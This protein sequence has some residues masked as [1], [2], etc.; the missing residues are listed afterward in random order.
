MSCIAC[1]RYL[2]DEC[3]TQPCCCRVSTKVTEVELES[4]PLKNAKVLKDP[5]STGRKRAVKVRTISPGDP[6]DWKLQKNCG[7]GK[8]PIV[9]CLDGEAKH[10]HHGPDKSTLNNE[11][12]NLH[13]LCNN[14]HNR[15]HNGNDWCIDSTLLHD[16]KPATVEEIAKNEADWLGG[17]FS[18]WT[19]KRQAFFKENK[20]IADEEH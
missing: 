3:Y 9:G 14:C 1:G 13:K 20:E 5:L 19:N 16:P 6:C 2:H 4:N 10:V 18:D 8:N 17:K 15:W 7:G 12:N 11:E